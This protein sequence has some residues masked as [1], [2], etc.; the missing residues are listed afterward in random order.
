MK[1]LA[2]TLLK[3]LAGMLFVALIVVNVQIGNSASTFFNTSNINQANAGNCP[4]GDDPCGFYRFPDGTKIG[5][6]GEVIVVTPEEN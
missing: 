3:S 2:K 6:F 5:E 4:V 1:N